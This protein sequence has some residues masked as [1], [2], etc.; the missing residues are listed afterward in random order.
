[1]ALC[2]AVDIMVPKRLCALY[3]VRPLKCFAF[4]YKIVYALTYPDKGEEAIK[5]TQDVLL[6]SG[7]AALLIA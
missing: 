1:M 3:S 4:V 7:P 2:V 6:D 5:R